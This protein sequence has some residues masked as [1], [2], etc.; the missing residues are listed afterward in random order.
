MTLLLRSIEALLD[1]R[2]WVDLL[3]LI[4]NS[5]AWDTDANTEQIISEP[6]EKEG[7]YKGLPQKSSDLDDEM[8]NGMALSIIVKRFNEYQLERSWI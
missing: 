8:D 4:E 3:F 2:T 1:R 7:R 6:I 5:R